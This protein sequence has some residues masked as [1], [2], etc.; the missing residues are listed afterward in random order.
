LKWISFDDEG[1]QEL[2][3]TAFREGLAT[4]TRSW[5]AHY[6]ELFNQEGI[7]L[8]DAYVWVQDLWTEEV[9]AEHAWVRVYIHPAWS[10]EVIV[11]Y[12]SLFHYESRTAL[13]FLAQICLF[14][15]GISLCSH[16]VSLRSPSLLRVS[17]RAS[18]LFGHFLG[19]SA[20]RF[21]ALFGKKCS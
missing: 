3:Q 15:T 1:M 7:L 21:W 18:R 19:K 12:V 10:M 4:L 6:L 5:D 20:G 13:I 9:D 16:W 2:L 14:P 8:Y 11:P 17:A